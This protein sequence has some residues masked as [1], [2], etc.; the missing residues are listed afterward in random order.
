[1]VKEVKRWETSD[2]QIFK[3][4][5]DA[6]RHEVNGM[7]REQLQQLKLSEEAIENIERNAA[8]MNQILNVYIA[9]TECED[10]EKD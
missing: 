7:L 6:N 4:K 3:K 8:Y 2:G 10:E 9:A 5:S 1:M